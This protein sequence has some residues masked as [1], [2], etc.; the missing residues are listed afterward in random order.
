MVRL[1]WTDM[2]NTITM[3][4]TTR[5]LLAAAGALVLGACATDASANDVEQAPTVDVPAVRPENVPDAT[6]APSTA[7]PHTETDVDPAA[8]PTTEPVVTTPVTSPPTTESADPIPTIPT[9]PTP[10]DVPEATPVAPCGEFEPLP[11]LP[12]SMPTI[13]IDTD[14]DGDGDAVTAY[15]AADGWHVRVVE[16][17][18]T[19]EAVVDSIA[20]WAYLAD[21]V[22]DGDHVE[23]VLVDNDTAGAWYFATDAAGCVGLLASPGDDLDEI[24]DFASDDD[25]GCGPL[26]SIPGDAV[27][28]SELW[29]DNG[30]GGED[31]YVSYFADGIWTLRVDLLNAQSEVVIPSAGV[32]GVEIIGMADVDPTYGGPELLA[33]VGGGASTVEIGIFSLLEGG[34]IFRYQADGGGDFGVLVGASTQWGEGMVCAGGLIFDTGYQREDDDT[35]TAWSTPY[36]P[37]SLGTFGLV[38]DVDGYY[39]EGLSP[40][41]TQAAL[42]ECGDLAL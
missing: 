19:S 15:G 37:V 25:L 17:G 34:C 33:T 20:G 18:V 9:P 22:V 5:L 12:D 36:Q 39:E 21:P 31:H 14:G 6:A 32:H 40:D 8:P 2:Q 24:D 16:D 28:G 29:V 1:L 30:D 7:P 10:A 27:I 38:P 4:T 26:P 23:I 42:F 35:Y 3:T 41:V 11:P 13:A